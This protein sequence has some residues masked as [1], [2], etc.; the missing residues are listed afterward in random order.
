MA[1]EKRT[2]HDRENEGFLQD[3]LLN[4]S[5]G[6][7]EERPPDYGPSRY[8]RQRIQLRRAK[9]IVYFVVNSFTMLILLRIVLKALGANEAN[10]FAWFLYTI[11]GPLVWPFLN[12]FGDPPRFGDQNQNVFEFSS[13]F[14]IIVYYFFAWVVVKIINFAMTRP[15]EEDL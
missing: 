2:V 5:A 11:T 10:V 9:K 14:A 7:Y 3:R 8:E 15:S 1:E 13:F 12:L 4:Q 6:A